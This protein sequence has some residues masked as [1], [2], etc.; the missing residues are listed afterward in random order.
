MHGDD[1]F[2]LNE[3]NNKRKQTKTKARQIK[4]IMKIHDDNLSQAYLSSYKHSN[5]LTKKQCQN[6]ADVTCVQRLLQ[7]VIFVL[8][9]HLRR[10]RAQNHCNQF[11]WWQSYLRPHCRRSSDHQMKT[12]TTNKNKGKTKQKKSVKH[13]LWKY[14]MTT[15]HKNI[16]HRTSTQTP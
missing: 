12:T 7:S 14:M 10:S 5:S 15:S 16:Y 1:G 11:R 9:L 13:Q 4:S 6:V 2:F 3:N 8:N